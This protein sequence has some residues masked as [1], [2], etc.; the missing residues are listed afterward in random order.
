MNELTKFLISPFLIEEDVFPN[1][2][3][4]SSIKKLIVCFVGRFQPPSLHHKKVYDW[5]CQKF[6]AGNVFIGTSNKIELPDSPLSFSE[7]KAIWVKHG[8]PTDKVVET[9][10]PYKSEE[11][12]Q[13]FEEKS[14]SVL[15]VFGQ[16]D[17]DRLMVRTKKTGEPGYFLPYAGNENKLIS[18]RKHGY[19]IVAPHF[20]VLVNGKELSGT[21]VR[22][23]LGSKKISD[24]GRKK[25]F[26]QIFGWYDE[27]LY[28]LIVPKFISST[29]EVA[30]PILEEVKLLKSLIENHAI[31]QLKTL[32]SKTTDSILSNFLL[33]NT[34]VIFTLKEITIN[35]IGSLPDVFSPKP[36]DCG[37]IAIK[38]IKLIDKP[39]EDLG[40]KPITFFRTGD[41]KK[42]GNLQSP[43]TDPKASAEAW[44]SYVSDIA[45]K[46]GY[47]ITD[48]IDSDESKKIDYSVDSMDDRS[49]YSDEDRKTPTMPDVNSGGVLCEGGNVF[50]KDGVISTI[51][52]NKADVI[53]TVKWLES[54]TGLPLIDNMLGT[55]GNKESSSDLD[56]SVD[57][58]KTSKEQL[59]SKLSNWCIKKKLNPK[60]YISKTGIIVHFKTPIR[61]EEKNG[62]VQTDF[63]FTDDME[64]QKFSLSSD[65]SSVYRGQNRHIILASIARSMG[66][67]W[68]YKDGLVDRVTEKPVPNGR[69]PDFIAKTL[70]GNSATG[71]DVSSVENIL[72]KLKTDPKKAE[73]LKDAIET[74]GKQGVVLTEGARIEHPEDMIFNDGSKGALR[75]IDILKDLPQ[76]SQNVTIKWDGNPAI[77]FGR[78][79]RGFV[80]TDKSGFTAKGYDGLTR[81]VEQ[82]PVML[83]NRPG[84]KT[85]LIRIHQKLFPLLQSIT[86]QGFRGFIQG[87]MLFFDKPRVE[88]N[89]WV[90]Q[91]NVVKY[92]IPVDGELGQKIKDAEIGIVIHSYIPQVGAS[93]QP[94]SDTKKLLSNPKVLVVSPNFTSTPSIAVDQNELKKAE[95]LVKSASS[96]IDATLDKSTLQKLKMTDFPML[97]K[98]FVNIKVRQ[99]NFDN[100]T[101]DFIKWISK[102]NL[103][104][105]KKQNVLKYIQA[106]LET[107]ED[108]FQI[109]ISISLVKTKAIQDLDKSSGGVKA[110]INNQPG[111]E[112]YVVSSDDDLLKLVDRFKFSKAN[113]EKNT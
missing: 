23:F 100:L 68:S 53:P 47:K 77:I 71:K 74:L 5:L 107:I 89:E 81:S 22:Q 82:V 62:F 30:T 96:K 20:S 55:T 25:L 36:E 19:F 86:P 35:P 112:G 52:I 49:D 56:L 21:N 58:K 65:P 60:E 111:H 26:Q 31:P 70:L 97:M 54:V 14:T 87:D 12:I 16:K 50:K 27:Y 15:F 113:F 102:A 94:F 44:K 106:N 46:I 88:N 48:F 79:D 34:H 28:H 93:P 72:E 91:P 110:S 80:L 11:I 73:K 4:K 101:T 78:D 99:G 76:K 98:Q 63:M 17:A 40:E 32:I 103:T 13:K 39:R 66:L 109:F 67:R 33:E 90:F 85:E 38:A 51:R 61:G 84:D 108:I 37:C 105:N 24:A 18:Y 41:V 59:T 95:S 42:D 64:F 104:E 2:N 10:S 57:A 6:G 69:N 9:K 3:E 1:L 43:M 92:S 29:N 7:K 45:N 8:V 83:S 75:T